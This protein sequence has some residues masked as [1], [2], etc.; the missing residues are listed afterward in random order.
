MWPSLLRV[1]VDEMRTR[2]M[3]PG[4]CFVQLG[5]VREGDEE[6]DDDAEPAAS[7]GYSRGN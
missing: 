1:A 7:V 3:M 5:L 2:M 4:P 6:A